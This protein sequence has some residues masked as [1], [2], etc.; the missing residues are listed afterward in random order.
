MFYMFQYHHIRTGIQFVL[1]TNITIVAITNFKP[2]Y[3]Y[4]TFK[5]HS[6]ILPVSNNTEVTN[7]LHIVT[8]YVSIMFI[9]VCVGCIH[10]TTTLKICAFLKI[11]YCQLHS[12]C[13]LL[14]VSFFSITICTM[15]S[16]P[17]DLCQYKQKT[18]PPIFILHSFIWYLIFLKD[19]FKCCPLFSL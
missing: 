19:L 13:F 11:W 1:T 17:S 7:I 14:S 4:K 5:V 9:N 3:D 10:E 6:R 2:D 16:K 15:D 12:K 8:W 18:V